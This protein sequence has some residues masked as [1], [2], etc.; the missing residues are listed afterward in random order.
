MSNILTNQIIVNG[1]NSGVIGMM[2][3]RRSEMRMRMCA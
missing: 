3:C 2:M 1:V